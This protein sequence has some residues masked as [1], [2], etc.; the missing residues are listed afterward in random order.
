MEKLKGVNLKNVL[1]IL[2]VGLIGFI[3]GTVITFEIV[4]NRLESLLNY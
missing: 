3:L 1:I 4:L 2:L